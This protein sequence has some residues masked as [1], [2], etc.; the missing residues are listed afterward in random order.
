LALGGG[1]H[2]GDRQ[3][4]QLPRGP[5]YLAWFGPEKVLGWLLDFGR[6][7][8]YDRLLYGSENSHTTVAP[9]LMLGLNDVATRL[10]LP[11]VPD[12]DMEKI[13]WRNTARLWKIPA[14]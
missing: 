14:A 12:A 11:R 2:G 9:G 1:G 3:A 13:L 4:R 6:I 5:A 8:G 10:G 7:C